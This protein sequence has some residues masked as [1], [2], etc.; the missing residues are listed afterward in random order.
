M[1]LHTFCLKFNHLVS[2]ICGPYVCGP[3]L[4][5]VWTLYGPYVDRMWTI[6]DP[7]WTLCGSYVDPM[8]S[9]LDVGYRAGV[10]LYMSWKQDT[11]L[12]P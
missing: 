3:Y 12:P 7:I 8:D 1:H 4:D 10:D 5:P 11:N 9:G 6:C 2:G